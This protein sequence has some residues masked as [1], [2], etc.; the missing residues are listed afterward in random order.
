KRLIDGKIQ[1]YVLPDFAQ[2]L[3]ALTVFRDRDGGLWIGTP[4]RGITHVHQGRTDVF[5]ASDGLSSDFV[6][7]F[8]EDSEGNIWVATLNGLDRFREFAVPAFTRKQGLSSYEDLSSVLV[9]RDGSLLVAAGDGLNRWNNGQFTAVGAGTRRLDVPR[10]LF[11]DSHGRIWA[12]SIDQFGY[13]ENDRVI[14]ITGIPA[15]VVRGIVED[16]AGDL[17]IANQNLGL[18]HLRGSQIIEQIPWIKFGHRD[19]A[20]SLAFDP[21]RGG[22]WIGFFKGGLTYFKDG[23]V[24]SSYSTDNGLGKGLVNDLR[25]DSD[26]ALFVATEGGLSRL[27]NNHFATLTISNGLPCDTIHWLIEDDDHSLWLNTTCG[28]VRITRVE[29]DRWAAAADTGEDTKVKVQATVFDMSDGVSSRSYPIG[30]VPQVAKS[31]DGKLWFPSY[32]GV[33]VV[34]P[35]HLP[36]NNLLPLVHVEQLIANH[37]TYDTTLDVGRVRL[38]SLIRDLE[39][40]YT[41]LSL[42][43][44]E[45]VF[46]R[47]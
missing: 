40:D 18:F 45:K 3:R 41:A 28:L 43:A 46:F 47:Y 38:P 7:S 42:V 32:D 15:G 30:F 9:V 10:S 14:A 11:Q 26:G 13:L 34:D 29:W 6:S 16:A 12:G 20:A 31:K 4:N 19:F 39:I 5:A 23:S 35:R 36:F 8:F 33:S 27:K 24:Q 44:P 25:V 17:W 21:V 1:A 2:P 37:Q 22:V